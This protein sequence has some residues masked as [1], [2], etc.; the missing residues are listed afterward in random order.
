M[1][2]FTVTITPTGT[3]RG[4]RAGQ[5]SG[6]KTTI[7]VDTTGGIARVTEL[8]VHTDGSGLSQQDLPIVD[9]AALVAALTPPAPTAP[10]T[11]SSTQV[12]AQ[13]S[14]RRRTRNPAAEAPKKSTQRRQRGRV[15]DQTPTR[16]TARTSRAYRRMPEQADVVAAWNDSRSTIQVADHFGVPRHTATSWLRRLRQTGVI[17]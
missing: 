3:G 14:R 17:E 6:S 13:P 4:A 7:Q 11:P 1:S 12:S 2:G 5:T 8:T 10:D 9:L 16:K 15:A